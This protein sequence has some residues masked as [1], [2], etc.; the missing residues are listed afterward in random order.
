VLFLGK[1][2]GTVLRQ[3][4]TSKLKNT[5]NIASLFMF[6]YYSHHSDYFVAKCKM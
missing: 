5:P 2:F 1:Y 3:R 4:E 6:N